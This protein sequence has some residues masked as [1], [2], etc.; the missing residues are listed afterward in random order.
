LALGERLGRVTLTAAPGTGDAF[1]RALVLRH[2]PSTTWLAGRPEDRADRLALIP[3]DGLI[4]S[5][6]AVPAR[7]IAGPGEVV[8]GHLVWPLTGAEVA[9]TEARLIVA[10]QDP[11][12]GRC[13]PFEPVPV[14]DLP[15]MRA[16]L[17]Q[18]QAGR[19]WLTLGRVDAKPRPDDQWTLRT[20]ASRVCSGSA[21]VAPGE[22]VQFNAA[23]PQALS[24]STTRLDV[25]IAAFGDAGTVALRLTGP[26]EAPLLTATLD[27]AG[28]DGAARSFPL[29][30]PLPPRPRR[31][32]LTVTAPPD[33]WVLVGPS[34]LA[35][36]DVPA[37]A[38][39]A[40]ESP[41]PPRI[42]D[43][44]VRTPTPVALPTRPA[45]PAASAAPTPTG[46]P[47]LDLA[48]L[49]ANPAQVRVSRGT[50]AAA[51]G[52]SLRVDAPAGTKAMVCTPDLPARALTASASLQVDADGPAELTV[53][54][55]RDGALLP[56]EAGAAASDR[57]RAIAG[58][59]THLSVDAAPP[60][61]ADAARACVRGFGATLQI[62]AWRVHARDP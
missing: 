26:D 56:A 7:E 28:L 25:S 17:H 60:P 46:P 59:P 33:A 51:T 18:T 22:T 1:I 6:R 30:T 31:V 52:A 53:R 38:W 34:Q 32:A 12:F 62:D 45:A 20:R 2:G 15:R 24:V 48:A 21:W 14:G 8:D 10:G 42:T 36:A 40:V 55:L 35:G 50:T 57:A 37:D 27:A 39:F 16:D 4:A 9:L 11:R 41:A 54:W 5:P 43:P 61:G 23:T 58:A 44:V 29:D 3:G 19:A 47:L 49:V 13:L